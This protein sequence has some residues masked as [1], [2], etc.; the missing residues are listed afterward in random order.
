MIKGQERRLILHEHDDDDDDDDDDGEDDKVDDLFEDT[1]DYGC[2]AKTCNVIVRCL[3]CTINIHL[4]LTVS[5][6]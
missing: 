5:V 3:L 4:C 2:M 1:F 6:C